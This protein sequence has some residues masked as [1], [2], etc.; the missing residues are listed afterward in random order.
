VARLG[1]AAGA[2]AFLL[3]RR[4][5]RVALENLD[6][7]FG[8]E[9]NAEQRFEI[10]RE[11]FRRLGENYACAVKTAC[12]TREELAQRVEWVGLDDRL[13]HEQRNI[14]GVVG[15]FAN[16][17]VYARITDHLPGWRVGTTYRALRQPALNRVL[18]ELRERSGVMFFERRDGAEPL[19][20]ELKAGRMLVALLSDQH[21]GDRGL[22]LPF[23]GHPA[24]CNPAAAV[25]ALRYQAALRSAVC[26][27]TGL[28]RWRIE[29]EPEIPLHDSD[30]HQRPP[31][32]VQREVNR[33]LE[34]AIRRDPANWFWVHRRWKP[35]SAW[36]RAQEALTKTAPTPH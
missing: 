33:R 9:M 26:Y 5:R 7:V 17:E 15:H 13:I 21:G 32:D 18:L 20:R 23:L 24:S 8:A 16:F 2:I 19:R 34:A 12:M 3:D 10:A 28:A 36:Q 29:I 30:G 1:R 25:L 31:L 22:W 11:N 27:R 4:H 14:V 35:A 6:R